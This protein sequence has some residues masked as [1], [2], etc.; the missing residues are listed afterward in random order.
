MRKSI[1]IGIMILILSIATLA[2]T[3]NNKQEAI[4]HIRELKKININDKSIN[5]E[6]I[7]IQLT[8][9]KICTLNYETE[10]IEYCKLCYNATYEELFLTNCITTTN[11]Y[12]SEEDNNIIL[13]NTLEEI[14]SKQVTTKRT[15][16]KYISRETK[17]N[18]LNIK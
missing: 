11:D 7:N 9:D 2:I 6:N 15:E 10:E 1:I 13:E 17:G 3:L 4:E 12:D 16:I 14:K 18:T 5:N 8:T